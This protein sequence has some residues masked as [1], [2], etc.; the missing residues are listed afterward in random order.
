MSSASDYI[1]KLKLS[2]QKEANSAAESR[3]FRAP[4]RDTVYDPH[5]IV[6]N[7]VHLENFKT[8][9]PQ[10]NTFSAKQISS[11]PSKTTG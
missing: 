11:N 4:T 1:Q 2:V 8:P 5:R 10:H 7:N 3:K 9:Q 6:K